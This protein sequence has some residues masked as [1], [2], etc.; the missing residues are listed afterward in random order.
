MSV[1]CVPSDV[2][3]AA[4]C[5]CLSPAEKDAV[6]TYLLAV[7]AGGSTDP[8]TLASASKAFQGIPEGTIKAVQV[9]LL[10]HIV[11]K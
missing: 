6:D 2:A 1:S 9:Y 3:K 11:N 5:F 10:C 4:K 8:K 7:I